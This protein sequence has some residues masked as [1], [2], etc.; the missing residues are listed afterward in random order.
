MRLNMRL[1]A[2]TGKALAVL[3]LG[4]NYTYYIFHGAAAFHVPYQDVGRGA[5]PPVERVTKE[6]RFSEPHCGCCMKPLS[7]SAH[8]KAVNKGAT[9]WVCSECDVE[10]RARGGQDSTEVWR[11]P[12]AAEGDSGCLCWSAAPKKEQLGRNARK[13][14]GKGHTSAKKQK[15][16]AQR[17]NKSQ[18]G[19]Q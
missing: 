5:R 4:G 10:L 9:F 12:T 16:M 19:G 15:W 3:N 13:M 14:I 17:M 1:P 2:Q 11:C 18:E 6:D 7:E 8:Y